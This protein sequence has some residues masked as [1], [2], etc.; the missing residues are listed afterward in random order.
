VSLVVQC[1][2][3]AKRI[4]VNLQRARRR[5]LI[6]FDY[7]V[8]CSTCAQHATQLGQAIRIMRSDFRRGTLWNMEWHQC[9]N[10]HLV[11]MRYLNDLFL[12]A[13][14]KFPF[15]GHE[16]LHHSCNV[17]HRVFATRF[18]ICNLLATN[19]CIIAAM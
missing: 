3:A 18:C 17:K 11:A 9:I 7:L 8:F 13:S 14:F 15:V 19:V 4:G 12:H 10:L 6:L 2:S 5:R 1:T 16:C